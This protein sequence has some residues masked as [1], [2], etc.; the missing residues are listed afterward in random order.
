MCTQ[1]RYALRCEKWGPNFFS[2]EASVGPRRSKADLWGD[3]VQYDELL[4]RSFGIRQVQWLKDFAYFCDREAKATEY[5]WGL[6]WC[7]GHVCRS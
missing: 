4:V 1:A 3:L 5:A 2:T 6:C 7:D